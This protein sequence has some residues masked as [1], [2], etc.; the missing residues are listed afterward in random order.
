MPKLNPE[1]QQKK[2]WKLLQKYH[3]LFQDFYIKYKI[4]FDSCDK[5]LEEFKEDLEKRFL[6]TKKESTE[7]IENEKKFAILFKKIS[8]TNLI[9]KDGSD[10]KSLSVYLTLAPNSFKHALGLLNNCVRKL[11][12]CKNYRDVNIVD[13]IDLFEKKEL[14]TSGR[15][16]LE[17]Q[18]SMSLPK[19]PSDIIKIILDY[20]V[21]DVRV[22]TRFLKQILKII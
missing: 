7:R 12:K 3:K 16:L 5:N 15:E 1:Q 2:I 8:I 20:I 13:E 9:L 18:I 17:K 4:L 11:I 6:W 21:L 14:K 19:I 10:F 22:S